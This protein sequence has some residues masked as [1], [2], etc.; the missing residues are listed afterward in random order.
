MGGGYFFICMPSEIAVS[1]SII[2]AIVSVVIIGYTSFEEVL[3][4]AL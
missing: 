4:A 1:T 2:N 3:T